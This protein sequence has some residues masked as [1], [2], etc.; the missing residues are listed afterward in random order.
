MPNTVQKNSTNPLTFYS[1]SFLVQIFLCEIDRLKP[2]KL[3]ALLV[4][5]VPVLVSHG[6]RASVGHAPVTHQDQ[7]RWGGPRGTVPGPWL[8]RAPE[9]RRYPIVSNRL[10]V[11]S[12]TATVVQKPGSRPRGPLHSFSGSR[13]R[14]TRLQSRRRVRR[15]RAPRFPEG[16]SRSHPL[17]Q[18]GTANTG[19]DRKRRPN[20]DRW[21]EAKH[22]S[23]LAAPSAVDYRLIPKALT[24]SNATSSLIT[25]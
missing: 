1:G 9:N 6:C 3:L 25:W 10:T 19:K 2:P 8:F 4:V 12:N 14:R 20:Q 17:E 5:R 18:R 11:T 23:G 13:P 15:C 24:T 22:L 16:K 7:G 21:F